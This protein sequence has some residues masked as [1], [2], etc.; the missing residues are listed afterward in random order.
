M[1]LAY[2]L[3]CSLFLIVVHLKVA[4]AHFLWLLLGTLM[5]IFKK[6]SFFRKS[7]GTIDVIG[8]QL[9]PI[10]RVEGRRRHN[11]EG[12]NIQVQAKTETHKKTLQL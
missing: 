12:N 7:S 5:Y 11:L 9:A 3:F 8:G 6:L 2:S 10:S 1:N 4:G